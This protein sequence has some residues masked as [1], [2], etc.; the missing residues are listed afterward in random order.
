MDTTATL[1]SAGGLPLEEQ[2]DLVF[3]LWDQIAESGWRPTP[4]PELLTE[5]DRRLA[6]HDADPGRAMTW[7]QVVAH[8]QR[9]H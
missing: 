4:A 6:A 9:S 8:A 2:L 5:F 7:E 3:R 1:Q